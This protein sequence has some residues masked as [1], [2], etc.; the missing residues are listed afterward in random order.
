MK[1][2]CGRFKSRIVNSD[3]KKANSKSLAAFVYIVCVYM[4]WNACLLRIHLTNE[5]YSHLLKAVLYICIGLIL[6]ECCQ[7]CHSHVV[8]LFSDRES[9][10]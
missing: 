5:K 9:I 3:T 4:V 8:L 6:Q 10:V 7:L 2:Y 1:Q